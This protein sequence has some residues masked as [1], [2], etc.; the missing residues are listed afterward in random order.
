M[1]V[2]ITNLVAGPLTIYTG[3]FGATEPV[4]TAVASAPG[5]AFTDMGATSGGA[6]LKLDQKF[7]ELKVD[8]LVDSAGRRLTDRDFS[9]KTNLAEATLANLKMALNSAGTITTSGTGA[10][11]N[12][13]YEPDAATSATQPTYICVLLDG[14]G[15]NGKRRR[16]I[17]RKCLNI[18]AVETEYKKDG[19]TLFT[20]EFAC[21][22][23][24]TSIKPFKIIDDTS[25]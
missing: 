3:T 22:W 19:Q 11:L 5:G 25:P 18:D 8:Q 9:V 23:V 7:F 4:D 14:Y 13:A 21:H 16:V 17:L 24:S 2:L 1:S 10:T 6:K 12:D 20:V 15:P